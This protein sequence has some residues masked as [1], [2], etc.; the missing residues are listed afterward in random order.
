MTTASGEPSYGLDHLQRHALVDGDAHEF[1]THEFDGERTLPDRGLKSKWGL[2]AAGAAAV[3][4]GTQGAGIA[5]LGGAIR[6]P[7]WLVFGAGG[8]FLAMLYQELQAKIGSPSQAQS[9]SF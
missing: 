5:A 9:A 3:A 1:E 7:L 8:A 2:S 6:V 4:F